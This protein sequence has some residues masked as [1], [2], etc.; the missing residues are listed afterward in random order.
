[1]PHPLLA[2]LPALLAYTPGSLHTLQRP[3]GLYSAPDT[4]DSHRTVR[5]AEVCGVEWGV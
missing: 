1:M 4:G 2:A 3:D 5:T